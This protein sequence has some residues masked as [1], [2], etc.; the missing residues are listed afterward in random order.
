MRVH[1]ISKETATAEGQNLTDYCLIAYEYVRWGL[2][3]VEFVLRTP[4]EGKSRCT[5]SEGNVVGQLLREI[6]DSGQMPDS[7]QPSTYQSSEEGKFQVK[8]LEDI[9]DKSVFEI[10][11][12]HSDIKPL[13]ADRNDTLTL[14]YKTDTTVCDGQLMKGWTFEALYQS[15]RA[16]KPPFLKC[17]FTLGDFHR[18]AE[19]SDT[20]LGYGSTFTSERDISI[21]MRGRNYRFSAFVDES[22]VQASS[23]GLVI[24]MNRHGLV[25][26]SDLGEADKDNNERIKDLSFEIPLIEH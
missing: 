13:L 10:Q 9:S 23:E 5:Y 7:Y 25:L 1:I 15:F 20:P 11:L 6:L 19:W 24:S 8:I 14:R 21:P 2:I 26:H 16:P 17:V 3:G 12:K 18:D 22:R 4:G